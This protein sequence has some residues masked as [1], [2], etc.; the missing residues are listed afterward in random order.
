MRPVLST[1]T[2]HPRCPQ[3][4]EVHTNSCDNIS[5]F[6]VDS[7]TSQES[8]EPVFIAAGDIRYGQTTLSLRSFLSGSLSFPSLSPYSS[9]PGATDLEA[10]KAQARRRRC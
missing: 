3:L 6:S 7:I 4:P 1:P 9:C 2:G 8:K 5:Q 10:V